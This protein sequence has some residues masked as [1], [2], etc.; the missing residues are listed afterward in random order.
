[1]VKVPVDCIHCKS[2]DVVKIGKQ[3]NGTQGVNAIFVEKPSKPHTKTME[4]H[5][6]QTTNNKNGLKR[7]W[8]TRHHTSPAH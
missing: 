1:V 8:N 3:P 4:L 7:Q 6:N 2:E 5:P